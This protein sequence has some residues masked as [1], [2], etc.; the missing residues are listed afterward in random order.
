MD[1]LLCY[2]WQQAGMGTRVERRSRVER[3]HLQDQLHVL[4]EICTIGPRKGHAEQ[5]APG[6]D[7]EEDE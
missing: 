5:V 3:C 6:T 4:R 2:D 7:T 1:W